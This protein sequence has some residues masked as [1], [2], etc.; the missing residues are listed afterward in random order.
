MLRCYKCKRE[1]HKGLN[2]TST[3]EQIEIDYSTNTN[4]AIVNTQDASA[5][6]NSVQNQNNLSPNN[7][8]AEQQTFKRPRQVLCGS[9]S[10]STTNS[11]KSPAKKVIKPDFNLLQ[12]KQKVESSEEKIKKIE[13]AL[14]P[15]NVAFNDASN[16][17]SFDFA[18]FVQ[19]IKNS[20]KNP[21]ILEEQ[22]KISNSI[23]DVINAIEKVYPFVT[24]RSTKTRLTKLKNKLTT[25]NFDEMNGSIL[26]EPMLSDS[27]SESSDSALY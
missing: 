27:E 7:D 15:G 12:K 18:Q 25:N 6:T 8:T 2:C 4:K 14:Q 23:T 22:K 21:K 10:S 16:K 26:N 11:N 9:D 1:G 17:W 13:I 19:F 5:F 24:D 3:E 20:Y